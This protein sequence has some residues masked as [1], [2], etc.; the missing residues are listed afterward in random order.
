MWSEPIETEI[1]IA[2]AVTAVGDFGH[3]MTTA[4]DTRAK[5]GCKPAH[6]TIC[7]TRGKKKNET[8][9]NK[10]EEKHGEEKAIGNMQAY[11]CS[12]ATGAVDNRG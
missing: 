5:R 9:N 6:Q 4:V 7:K 2:N 11:S 8:K 12:T 3:A 10:K 1:H